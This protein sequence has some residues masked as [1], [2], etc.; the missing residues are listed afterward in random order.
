MLLPVYRTTVRLGF[1]QKRLLEGFS[2]PLLRNFHAG[3]NLAQEIKDPY[4]TLGVPRN[5]TAANI[6]K[7]YYKLAK[8]YHPDLNKGDG[9]DQR[10]HDLQN[11]Y[12]ILSDEN[13]R[14]QY[15]QF[16]AAAFNQDAGGAAGGHGG[17]GGFG[18]GFGGFGSG[19]FS[20]YGDFGGMN[21]EDLFGAAFRNARRGEENFSSRVV[22]EYSGDNVDILHTVPFK[23]AVF[24]VQGVEFK[25]SA[26]DQCGT[27]SGS[28][29]KQNAKRSQCSSC[30]GTGTHVHIQ[31]GFQ[32]AS[33]CTTCDGEGTQIR[34]SDRC[35]TCQGAGVEFKRDKSVKIDI[36]HGIQDGDVIRLSGKGSYPFVQIDPAKPHATRA[37]RGDL[38]V[39]LRVQKDPRFEVKNNNEIWHVLDLP[40]TTAAL[41][42]TVSVPTVDG[43]QIRLKV[44]PGTQHLQV[45]SIP[46]RG[47]P[48]GRLGLRGDMKVQFRIILRKPQSKAETYLWEA[49]ADISNDTTAKRTANLGFSSSSTS[50]PSSSSDAVANP[51]EPGALRKL[52]NFISKAFKSITGD[53]KK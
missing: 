43:D 6:K 48:R 31:G 28:G 36:P 38:R 2:S 16:G 26:Y 41:G 49:L 45:T 13:K 32:M 47:V 33:T 18:G 5:A 15:D 51:D 53:G 34:R 11:A 44:L 40:I 19:G 23:D 9:A 37:H 35:G 50:S 39:R 29:L 22:R 3:R 10:F 42:G 46:N 17:F 7:A 20:S 24:G 30:N 8:Q 25:Y 27:C 1:R 21:F 52:E 12:E 14:R 4:K